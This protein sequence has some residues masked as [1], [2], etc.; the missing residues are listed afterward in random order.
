MS[1][2]LILAG[3]LAAFGV[4]GVGRAAA[5][6]PIE[7]QEERCLP[8]SCLPPA[9]P[10]D[11]RATTV[12]AGSVTLEWTY[13]VR[14]L[15][16]RNVLDRRQL[17]GGAWMRLY[18]ESSP[19]DGAVAFT[20]TDVSANTGYCYRV[21]SENPISASP[22]ETCLVATST[23]PTAPPDL[24]AIAVSD[25][26][27]SLSWSDVALNEEGSQLQWR[28]MDDPTGTIPIG[29]WIAAATYGLGGTGAMSPVEELLL[30]D[31][32]F[33]FRLKVWNFHG[34]AYSNQACAKTYREPSPIIRPAVGPNGVAI[35]RDPPQPPLCPQF[36]C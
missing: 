25:H 22:A 8:P 31:T 16:E 32:N 10:A 20:D 19:S 14:G 11:F 27:I 12:T 30:F 3:V 4:I 6:I 24:Q 7:D 35:L 9:P 13:D 21:S 17:P 1:R 26:Q 33:C 2:I 28:M 23:P 29:P 15:D 18:E 36:P 34:T 5:D